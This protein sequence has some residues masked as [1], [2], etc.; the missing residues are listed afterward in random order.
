MQISIII[1]VNGKEKENEKKK[2]TVE[3]WS[4]GII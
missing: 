4:V 3:F 2:E 1:K